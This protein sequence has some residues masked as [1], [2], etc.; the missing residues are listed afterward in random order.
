[1]QAYIKQTQQLSQLFTIAITIEGLT[2]HVWTHAAGIVI[3]DTPLMQH[4][5]LAPGTLQT[6]ITQAAMNELQAEGLINFDILGLRNL[7]LIERMGQTIE[8][9]TGKKLHI[10]DVQE[11]A[12]KVFHL[13]QSDRTNGVFQLESQGMKNVLASLKPSSMDDIVAINALY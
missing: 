10:E 12:D 3:S 8:C 11:N 2:R 1:L 4:V 9:A 6:H 5:P 7:T 13:L